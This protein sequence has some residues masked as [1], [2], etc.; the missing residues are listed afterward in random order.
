MREWII[1]KKTSADGKLYHFAYRLPY[2]STKI[3]D[4]LKCTHLQW[5]NQQYK[6][7]TII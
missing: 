3:E 7:L 6:D 2:N 1:V 5:L 4:L